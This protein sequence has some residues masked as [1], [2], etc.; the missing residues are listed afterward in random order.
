ML[1]IHVLG[2]QYA[3]SVLCMNEQICYLSVRRAWV[4]N[5]SAVVLMMILVLAG[6]TAGCIGEK[7]IDKLTGEDK[8]ND[9]D[10]K[11]DK[12]C[13][14]KCMETEE[15]TEEECE[16]RCQEEKK[17]SSE[18]SEESSDETQDSPEQGAEV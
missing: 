3:S 1:S 18:Q 7:Y 15:Y 9:K 14:K 6:S 8:D 4:M 11:C 17:D 2:H 13:V 16:Q 10:R 5:K 12:K